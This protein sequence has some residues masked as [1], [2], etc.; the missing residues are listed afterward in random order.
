M[1]LLANA[2]TRATDTIANAADPHNGVLGSGFFVPTCEMARWPMGGTANEV[3]LGWYATIRSTIARFDDFVLGEDAEPSVG[4]DAMEAAEVREPVPSRL[5][6]NSP[7]VFITRP[8]TMSCYRGCYHCGSPLAACWNSSQ[9]ASWTEW[10]GPINAANGKGY[11]SSL[12]PVLP[13]VPY[14]PLGK[15]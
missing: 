14:G 7:T 1:F 5:G 13:A 8:S 12:L 6:T 4:V 3:V 2:M 9:P 10:S 15:P 11:F